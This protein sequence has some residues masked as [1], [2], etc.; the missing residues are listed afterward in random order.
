MQRETWQTP[1]IGRDSKVD[2]KFGVDWSNQKLY[3]LLSLEDTT[4]PFWCERG[5][6]L[7]RKSRIALWHLLFFL[8][9]YVRENKKKFTL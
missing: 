9:H 1:I 2:P 8:F 6:R 4:S 3:S 5:E 7:G